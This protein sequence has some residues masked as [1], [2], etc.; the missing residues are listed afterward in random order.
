MSIL[1]L[2]LE[3][4]INN[5]GE[6]AIGTH[7]A[8]PFHPDNRIVWIGWK[9]QADEGIYKR[10]EL[11]SASKGL[12][13]FSITPNPEGA[14]LLVAQNVSFDLEHL[15][16]EDDRW[17]EW[18]GNGKVWDV[19]LAEYLLTGQQHKWASLDELST[20]YGGTVKDS[21]MKEYWEAGVCTSDIPDDE[22]EPYLHDDVLNLQTIY[23]AQHKKAVRLGML[24]LIESQ[25]DA[26]LATI[27]MEYNGMYFDKSVAEREAF[28]LREEYNKIES[29]LKAAINVIVPLLEEDEINPN[30]NQ[31][32]SSVLFGGTIKVVRKLPIMNEDGECVRYKSGMKKGL[33]KKKNTPMEFTSEGLFESK[34]A[35]GANGSY[36]VG[37]DILTKLE[38]DTGLIENILKL[39]EFKKQLSTYFE[40]YAQ[41]VFPDGC[42]H[43]SLNH[44]QT[45]TGRLSSSKPNLQ[46]ISSR[47]S[48]E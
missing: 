19:M 48:G 41:L 46:N 25:M 6:D 37:N 39:R 12:H 45:N 38:D 28:F 7:Q 35:V 9:W 20:K 32:I 27:M 30:S 24:P 13:R 10:K 18:T 15:M 26:R 47:T 11:T 8:S 44:C 16:M 22:I 17:V 2:D 1:Y 14:S 3:T 34:V 42:I 29:A 36:P 33:I 5:R 40:G 43:G 21:R 31:Q 23:H 4:T